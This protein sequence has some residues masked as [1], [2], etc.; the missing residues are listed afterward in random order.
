M[1]K[2]L[3]MSL[4]ALFITITSCDQNTEIEFNP[5]TELLKS[6]LIGTWNWDST[7]NETGIAQVSDYTMDSI[8]TIQTKT[9]AKVVPGCNFPRKL[10]LTS[11]I[12][13]SFPS[14]G[15]GQ[16][17]LK[18]IGDLYGNMPCGTQP[19]NHNSTWFVLSSNGGYFNKGEIYAG[20]LVE[21]SSVI[22]NQYILFR[23]SIKELT[24]NTLQ[25]G[26]SIS[27]PN[28]SNEGALRNYTTHRKI[29]YFSR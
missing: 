1:K 16:E 10:T 11:D 21:F 22:P 5:S 18:A 25:V 6:K 20:P 7:V 23:V 8:V 28:S 27:A 4:M 26:Y 3:L 19:I 2:I 24:T 12:D 13:P 17:P 15:N 14:S 29:G 9:V